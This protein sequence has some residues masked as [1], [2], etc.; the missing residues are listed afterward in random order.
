MPDRAKAAARLFLMIAVVLATYIGANAMDMAR[1]AE[2]GTLWRALRDGSA[3]AM[4]RHA[5]APGTGDPAN[6]EL[7]DCTTQRNLSDE[8]RRQVA[9]I[10]DRFRENGIDEATVMASAWCRTRDT[11]LLLALGPVET[12]TPLNS[13]FGEPDRREAQT[14]A[15]RAWLRDHESVR[16]LVLVTHQVNIAALTG[17]YPRSGEVVVIQL[18]PSGEIAVLGRL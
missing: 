6:F 9:S 12:L 2:E 15:L 17:V 5:I 16:P 11:A 10:G 18:Q 7:G 13:F 8:G 3:V 1:A 14:Q 4:I